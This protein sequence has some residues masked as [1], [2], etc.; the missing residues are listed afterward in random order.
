M[1]ASAQWC[2]RLS[3]RFA[4]RAV[5][6][7]VVHLSNYASEFVVVGDG[8]PLVLVPG[9]AGGIELLGRLISVLAERSRVFCF[10]LRGERE[11]V[12]GR[13]PAS[14]ADFADD[15]SE[16]IDA[17]LLERPAVAGVSFGSAIGLEFALRYPRQLN[18]LVLHGVEPHFRQ[19]L[20]GQI[21]RLALE[22]YPLPRDNAFFNQFFRLLFARREFVGP[23]FDFVV[24]QCWKTDQ[25]VLA[26]RLRML[27]DFDVRGRLGEVRV[28]SLVVAG[29]SDA[30]VSLAAQREL[31]KS[32]A[33]ARF[34][35]IPASGHLCFLTRP[36]AFAEHVASL[37]GRAESSGLPLVA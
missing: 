28:P 8:A 24:E 16:F 10:E 19:S 21:A 17:M 27:A 31:A 22:E 9:L 32:I 20:G 26:H 23:L 36:R 11:L 2:R 12:A 5:D 33:G 18:S 29:E 7:G 6:R 1:R 15:L 25:S 14:F 37:V 30:I 3:Q 4:A 34:A 35:S 13:V